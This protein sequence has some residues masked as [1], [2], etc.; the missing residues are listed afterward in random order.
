M[1]D[2][3]DISGILA[4]DQKAGARMIRLIEGDAPLAFEGLKALYPHSGHAFIIGIT[5][6]PGV[7]KSTLING[8]I[9]AFRKL[10][11]KVGVIA[12]DPTSPFSG[13]AILGDRL[14]MQAHATDEKVF[15]RSMASRGQAGGLSRA[16]K[17]A[18][19][20]LDAM[21]YQI[22]IIETVG[23]GQG[24]FEVAFFA[25]SI[26]IVTVP[27]TCDGIQ[28]VKAGI[29]ETG[30]IFIVNK[31]DPVTGDPAGENPA[32]G[33]TADADVSVHQL[34]M[35]LAM[36]RSHE[37]GRLSGGRNSDGRNSGGWKPRVLK[38]NALDGQGTEELA[39]AFLA[40][41][42]FM[43][44]NNLMAEKRRRQE[45]AYFNALLRDITLKRLLNFMENAPEYRDVLDKLEA[46][47]INPVSAAEK[48]VKKLIL[49]P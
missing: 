14:R 46:R 2:M 9:T 37:T 38:T 26:G 1:P 29:L 36:G 4:G 24:E 16:T 13:G 22:I 30:D 27:G 17:D 11:F 31:R 3:P 35:M 33:N 21:G 40:H 48:M 6:S 8:L 10:D 23:A 18:A 5:G 43:K 15:I 41:Q 20:V 28:A 34:S 49:S 39:A 44:I 32:D 42:G 45:T 19:V 47:E 25:H 12:V 7:G